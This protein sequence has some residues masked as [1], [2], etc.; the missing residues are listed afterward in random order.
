[1]GYPQSQM[2]SKLYL[3]PLPDKPASASLIDILRG[4]V[5]K[6]IAAVVNLHKGN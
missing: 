4:I 5:A 2:N 1:M 6:A 3:D